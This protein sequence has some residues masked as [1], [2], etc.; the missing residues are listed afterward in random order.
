MSRN[1][2]AV[3]LNVQYSMLIFF[4]TELPGSDIRIATI[5]GNPEAC[6]QARRMVLDIINEVLY[7]Y[8]CQVLYML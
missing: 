3:A 1:F 2:S 6:A 7:D 8:V 5:S 4:L